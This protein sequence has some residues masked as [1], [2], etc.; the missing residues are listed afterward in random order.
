MGGHRSSALL[1]QQRLAE[2]TF[3]RLIANAPQTHYASR[4]TKVILKCFALPTE[5]EETKRFPGP[6]LSGIEYVTDALCT[7]AICSCN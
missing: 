6:H 7:S 2:H 3:A 1:S 4:D 5:K